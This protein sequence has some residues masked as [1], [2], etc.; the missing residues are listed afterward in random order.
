[1]Q[2]IATFGVDVTMAEPTEERL[3][4]A[5]GQ[6]VVAEMSPLTNMTSS[7]V[8]KRG[9]SGTVSSP[10]TKIIWKSIQIPPGGLQILLLH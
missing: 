7:Q 1:M 2:K 6:E 9:P 8:E 10:T 3:L 5:A 4:E